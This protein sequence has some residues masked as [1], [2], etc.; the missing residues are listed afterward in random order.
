MCPIDAA[1]EQPSLPTGLY[2]AVL[3]VVLLLNAFTLLTPVN[4]QEAKPAPETDPAEEA[5]PD[6]PTLLGDMVVTTQKREQS[7]QDVPASVTAFDAAQLEAV[8]LRDLRDLTIGIPNVGFDEIGTSRGTANFSIRG[9]GINSSI[10]SL[11]PT[12]GVFVDGVYMGTNSLMV[13]DTFDLDS[14][15]VARGPQGVLFGRNVV[16]GAV[17]LNTRAPTDEYE[18]TLRSAIEGGGKA[19]NF[20]NSATLNA[21]LTDTL[22][23][24]FTVHSNQDQG[25]FKNQRDGKAFGAQDTL[26]LRPVLSWRPTE[27]FDLT[28]RYEYQ[29]IESDGPAAQNVDYYDRRD[30]TFYVDEDGYLDAETHFF[31]TRADW[32]VAFGNGTITDIFAWRKARGDAFS[33]IDGQ[34][35]DSVHPLRQF[36]LGTDQETEQFSNELRYAGTFFNRLQLTTGVYYFTNSLDYFETRDLGF[37]NG[38]LIHQFGGGYYDVDTLGLFLNLDYDL[39]DWLTLTGG[40]RYTHEEKEADI[41]YLPSNQVVN[42][43]DDLGCHML[44][45]RRCPIDSSDDASWNSLSPKIGLTLRPV[46]QLMLYWHWTR[47][48]RSGNYNVRIVGIRAADQ[49]GPSDEEQVD[50]FELGFKTTLGARARLNGAVFFNII[51]DMQRD[52]LIPGGP[53]GSV[54]DIANTANAEIFGVELDSSF[55]LTDTLVLQGSMG[56]LDAKYTDIWYDLNGDGITDGKD[57]A[58]DLI[59][60]PVWTYSL[61]LRHSVRLGARFRLDSR[62]HYAYRDREY[63]QDNNSLYNRQL[64][65]VEA[66]LDLHLDNSQ[67]VIGLYGKNLLNEAGHGINFVSRNPRSGIGSFS[68]LSKGRIYGLE[69]TYHF[70]GV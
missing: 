65:K 52:V 1:D 28:L 9:M 19:P 21:P 37:A 4:A 63:S 6:T 35:A 3:T 39:T 38:P 43:P 54:Q 68:P 18:A 13:Y 40:L 2:V 64:K 11:D 66:G 10:P 22:A 26:M 53:S 23:A 7:I 41:A 47:G 30:H 25:W 15:E 32:E 5:A 51:K 24:R 16:S 29:S 70:R 36:N 33:D 12:V 69:L 67:W 61:G 17:L 55:V 20:F 42:D 46:D 62:V 14:I 44:R 45:G 31:N 59:R 27:N 50:N 34:P 58:L 57:Q 48:F 8:K 49:E 56:F 60:A